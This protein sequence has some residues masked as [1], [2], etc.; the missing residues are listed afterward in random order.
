M[1]TPIGFIILSHSNPEQLL[2]LVQC[3]QRLYDNPPIA[4][5]H[6]LSQSP[7]RLT[8]FPS[9]VRFVTPH[10]ETRWGKF[11][12]VEAA[13]R[14]LQLLY[15]NAAPDWFVLLSAADYPT[16]QPDKVID[17][18]RSSG[19]DAFLDFR[20]A[21]RIASDHPHLL[22]DNPAL[23]HF[24]SPG[25]LALAWRRYVGLN[26]WIPVIRSGPRLGRHTIGL[27]I[28]ALNSPFRPN[29]KCFYGDHW[30]GGNQ[31]VAKILLSPNEEHMRLRHHLRWRVSPDECYY[32]TII[33]NEPGL[34]ITKATRRFAEWQGGGA[35]PK[36]LEIQDLPAIFSSQAHFARKFDSDSPA[37]DEI[38]RVIFS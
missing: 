10:I 20:E 21:T 34:K 27:P 7:I 35:H 5:H 37:I 36:I 22:P 3:L 12:V 25:N 18:L 16:M 24:V 1:S 19:M 17:E 13:L 26:I 38:N 30:F 4:C 15:Q 11:S 14:A 29:F 31:R 33:A 2:R 8:D 23:Q 32:H 9:D 28:K 6:D